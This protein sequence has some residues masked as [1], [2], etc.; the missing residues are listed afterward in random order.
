MLWFRLHLMEFRNTDSS[1]GKF[2]Q[3]NSL[4]IRPRPS[5]PVG[6]ASEPL[7]S[8]IT[9]FVYLQPS[10]YIHFNF[11][12]FHEQLIR[13]LEIWF[14]L[15]TR[16]GEF[17]GFFHRHPIAQGAIWAF[18]TKHSSPSLHSWISAELTLSLSMVINA[19]WLAGWRKV[20]IKRIL[21]LNL[22]NLNN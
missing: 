12:H 3:T 7:E 18:L 17:I 5:S 10:I 21:N 20:N 22:L 9:S 15:Y 14:R 8:G 11:V 4:G 16:Q 13:Y 1:M 19:A 6:D 2:S